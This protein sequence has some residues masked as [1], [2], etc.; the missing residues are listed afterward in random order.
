M[1]A[2]LIEFIINH[3]VLSGMF[4]VLLVLLIV[5]EMRK[6]GQSLSSRELTALVNSYKVVVLDVRAQKDFSAGHIVD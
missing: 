6:G 3:Y 1:F 4:A 5:T 2:N